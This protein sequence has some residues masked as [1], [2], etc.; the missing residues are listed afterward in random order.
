MIQCLQLIKT[1]VQRERRWLQKTWFPIHLT[2]LT[3][4]TSNKYPQVETTNRSSTKKKPAHN[5]NV[6]N[7]CPTI[8]STNHTR[9]STKTKPKIIN[10]SKRTL[11]QSQIALLCKGPKFCPSTRGNYIHTNADSKDFTIKGKIFWL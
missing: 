5:T 1:T 11:T 9:E 3:V 4:N 10:I 8:E 2:T 7:Q 6:T